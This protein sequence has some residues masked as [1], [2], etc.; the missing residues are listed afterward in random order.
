MNFKLACN[1]RSRTSEAFKSQNVKKMNETFDLLGCS[2][3]FFKS[4]NIHE[5]YGYLT[6]ENYGSVR[7]IDHCLAIASFELLDEKEMKKCLN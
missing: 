1:L 7:Q 5:L 6:V 2:H 3:S 4:W